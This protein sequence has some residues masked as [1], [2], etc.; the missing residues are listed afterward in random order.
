MKLKLHPFKAK[1]R[2]NR[3]ALQTG[4]FNFTGIWKPNKKSTAV[5]IYQF[6]LHGFA[7]V[8]TGLLQIGSDTANKFRNKCALA[9]CGQGYKGFAPL[10]HRLSW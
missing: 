7:F 8:L 6:N 2:L 10:G 4:T 5:N 1:A 9:R 3:A